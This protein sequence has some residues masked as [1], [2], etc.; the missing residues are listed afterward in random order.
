MVLYKNLK[1]VR[2][3][4]RIRNHYISFPV[5]K[6]NYIN[7]DPYFKDAKFMK[8]FNKRLTS[9]GW[10]IKYCEKNIIII[11]VLF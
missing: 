6:G 9:E 1:R 3:T 8:M 11:I 2:E 5:D 4:W 10:S 7:I